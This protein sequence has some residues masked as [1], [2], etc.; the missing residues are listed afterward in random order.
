MGKKYEK[1]GPQE[2]PHAP[3]RPAWARASTQTTSTCPW[4]AGLR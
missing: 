1:F 2:M 4:T 3:P